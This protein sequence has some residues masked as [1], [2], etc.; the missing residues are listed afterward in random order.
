MLTAAAAFRRVQSA[1]GVLQS[2]TSDVH[3]F[4]LDAMPE[5]FA[6]VPRRSRRLHRCHPQV[7]VMVQ[8]REQR[9]AAALL[10][11]VVYQRR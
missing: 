6:P 4:L 2:S 10:Y 9:R 5:E 3:S 8:A 1:F 7:A 11:H